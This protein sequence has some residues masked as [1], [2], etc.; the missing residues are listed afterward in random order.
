[1]EVK[2]CPML[3]SQKAGVLS[4]WVRGEVGLFGRLRARLPGLIRA[5]FGFGGVGRVAVG[6]QA[7][8]LGAV[9]YEPGEREDDDEY[10]DSEYERGG[11][12][13]EPVVVG[14][15]R[16]G[17]RGNYGEGAYPA[18]G[19]GEAHRL[20]AVADEPVVQHGHER[21]PTAE[22]LPQ[23]DDYI[24]EVEHPEAGELPA[25][26]GDV[27][28]LAEEYPAQPHDGHAYEDEAAGAEPVHQVALY[29]AEYA[30]LDAGEGEC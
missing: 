14:V 27:L 15:N 18:D 29:G 12:P 1:M 8:F 2:P 30:A 17:E 26:Y 21:E 10:D 6:E 25:E 23:R 3:M 28:N 4:A 11:G 24:D 9:S 20:G 19:V 7:V 13:S 22:S 16:P 5:G